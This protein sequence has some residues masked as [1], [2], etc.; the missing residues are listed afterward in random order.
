MVPLSAWR[1]MQPIRQTDESTRKANFSTMASDAAQIV[2][3]A[4]AVQIVLSSRNREQ[5]RDD[6]RG[7][8]NQKSWNWRVCLR[9]SAAV[10]GSSLSTGAP[11][12]VQEVA[13]RGMPAIRQLLAA[14]LFLLCCVRAAADPAGLIS[15]SPNVIESSGWPPVVTLTVRSQGFRSAPALRLYGLAANTSQLAVERNCTVVSARSAVF[16]IPR[17]A[18]AR[19]GSRFP[20]ELRL[21][22]PCLLRLTARSPAQQD[23]RASVVRQR[24]VVRRGDRRTGR[25][26]QRAVAAAGAG[27]AGQREAAHDG[28]QLRRRG[29]RVAD[30]RARRG[31]IRYAPASLVPQQ[32]LCPLA[33]LTSRVSV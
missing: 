14:A 32:P 13:R 17:A 15:L 5:K 29:V 25:G 11:Q 28:R 27:A 9:F 24:Q 31:R 12:R 6:S 26:G 33:Q 7:A 23:P 8:A 18:I 1:L 2:N 20:K 19:L 16:A 4:A 3:N 21:S 22:L 10:A 30:C